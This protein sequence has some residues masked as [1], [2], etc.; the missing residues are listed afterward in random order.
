MSPVAVVTMDQPP[1]R[2][3]FGVTVFGT[4]IDRGA[5][6]RPDGATARWRWGWNAAGSVRR[7]GYSE[8]SAR[9]RVS[10]VRA[11]PIRPTNP[12]H[13]VTVAAR[14]RSPANHAVE[15]TPTARGPTA[16]R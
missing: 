4:L 1:F 11:T 15:V 8:G 3:R 9:P 6:R 13:E 2:V 16:V 10:G 5:L 7:Q 12:I 14:P